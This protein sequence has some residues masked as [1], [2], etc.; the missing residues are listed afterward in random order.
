MWFNIF[1][2]WLC[3]NDIQLKMLRVHGFYPD[4]IQKKITDLQKYDQGRA[5]GQSFS[6]KV[7]NQHWYFKA[8]SIHNVYQMYYFSFYGKWKSS[9]YCLPCSQTHTQTTLLFSLHWIQHRLKYTF[10]LKTLS[11]SLI[12]W[13]THLLAQSMCE[14]QTVKGVKLYNF[15][16]ERAWLLFFEG[17]CGMSF[18]RF[19]AFYYYTIL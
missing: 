1:V 14:V 17:N 12:V 10:L 19:C 2:H 16:V 4:Q 15:T 13:H 11:L 5:Q 6:C 3:W 18:A 9:I 7:R 8:N